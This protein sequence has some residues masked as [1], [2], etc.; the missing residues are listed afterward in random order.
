[1]GRIAAQSRADAPASVWAQPRMAEAG[2][3]DRRVEFTYQAADG[4]QS[5]IIKATKPG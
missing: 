3:I 1:M 4:M 5:A 2:F